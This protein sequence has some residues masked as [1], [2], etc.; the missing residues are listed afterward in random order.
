MEEAIKIFTLDRVIS[1][2]VVIV[3]SIF[4]YSIINKVILSTRSKSKFKLMISS[5]SETYI[6]MF[7]SVLKYV[8]LTVTVLIIL[9]IYDINVSSMLAGIGILGAVFGLAMQDALK[10]IIRGINIISDDYF[11]VGDVIKFGDVVGKVLVIGLKTTKVLDINTQNVV[12]I[13]NRNIEQIQIVSKQLD[14]EV[15][16]SYELSKSMAEDV[17]LQMLDIIK[18]NLN[19]EAEYKGINKLDDSSINYLIRIW[20]DQEVKPQIRRNAICL[21]VD[22]LEK[23][24]I[25]IPYNQIDIHNK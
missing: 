24:G 25:E 6:K 2:L 9:Q 20:C 8:L 5:K 22:V 3:I 21:I 4:I 17:I 23:N 12:S 11:A 7:S 15:P 19:V 16:L 13:A 14:I 1:S 18:K 10:D